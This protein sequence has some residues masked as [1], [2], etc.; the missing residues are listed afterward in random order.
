M[1]QPLQFTVSPAEQEKARPFIA[2]HKHP[3]LKD[4]ADGGNVIAWMFCQISVGVI[5]RV[6]CIHCN[7]WMDVTDYSAW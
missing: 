2:T 7:T 1:S 3:E 5:I 4:V 6:Y